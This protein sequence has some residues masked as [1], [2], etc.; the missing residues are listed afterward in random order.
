M[1][2]PTS[3]L[4]PES[5]NGILDLVG[6]V[7]KRGDISIIITTHQLKVARRLADTVVFM[8][9]GRIV[10]SG[11]AIELLTKAVDPKTVRFVE[12]FG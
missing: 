3:A 1:D 5:V 10:E 8:D 4:D 12:A 11:S 7:K 9:N 2:E 6:E